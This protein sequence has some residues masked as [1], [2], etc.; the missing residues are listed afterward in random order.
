MCGWLRYICKRKVLSSFT[1]CWHLHQRGCWRCRKESQAAQ[2]KD[3]AKHN[4]M[5]LCEVFK[6][7]KLKIKD[8]GGA[9][10][11]WREKFTGL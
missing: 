3:R 5:M 7:M 6:Y 11:A 4:L 9:S 10:K 8:A 1:M 2:H